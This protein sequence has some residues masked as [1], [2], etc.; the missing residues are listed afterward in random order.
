MLVAALPALYYLSQ[1]IQM[2]G[3]LRYSSLLF[4]LI[5]AVVLMVCSLW[6]V[7]IPAL[8][9]GAGLLIAG[10]VSNQAGRRQTASLEAQR[11][12]LCR[13]YGNDDPS[14]WVALA[15]IWQTQWQDY[16]RRL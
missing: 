13:R 14:R 4:L 7:G 10:A 11:Q 8:V 3:V 5:L 6:A 2:E 12:E 9:I 15:E 1:T 16:E